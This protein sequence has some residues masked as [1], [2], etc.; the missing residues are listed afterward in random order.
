MGFPSN[1][2]EI[3]FGG[4]LVE[5]DYWQC[6]LR[7]RST[8]PKTDAEWI[9]GIAGLSADLTTPLAAAVADADTHT[10]TWAYLDKVSVAAIDIGGH[11]ALGSDADVTMT[12]PGTGGHGGQNGIP[13]QICTAV[14]LNTVAHR[15][16][17]HKGRFY[18]PGAAMASLESSGEVNG[19]AG[20]AMATSFWT[21]LSNI[22]DA[23][24]AAFDVNVNLCVIS[25]VGAGASHD[26]TSVSIGSV[27]DTQ[28][29]R[30]R[31]VTEHYITRP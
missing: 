4:Q 29:R 23:L 2:L 12:A 31:Q 7:A 27:L 26:V 10:S 13:P 1:H 30:R 19:T 22:N 8:V 11:Y 20:A 14:T 25:A 21:M 9:V 18:W 16:L 3:T 5:T 28:R 17:A 15:G 6:R 24:H